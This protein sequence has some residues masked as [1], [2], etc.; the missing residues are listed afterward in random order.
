MF[1]P[2]PTQIET[3]D[4]S[5]SLHFA[6]KEI[7]VFGNTLFRRSTSEIAHNLE[8]SFLSMVTNNII[9]NRNDKMIF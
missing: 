9:I 8:G 6:A 3:I 1:L 4:S 2:N 7:T 5:T